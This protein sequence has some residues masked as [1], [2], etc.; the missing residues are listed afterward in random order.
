MRQF[1]VWLGCLFISCLSYALPFDCQKQ[2][3][4]AVVDAG[5][6]GS[7]LHVYTYDLDR[8][9]TPIHIQEQWV[10]KVSPGLASLTPSEIPNYL[11]QLIKSLPQTGLPV[12]F[13]STAGMRLLSNAQQEALYQGVKAWFSKQP[14]MHLQALKTISGAEEGV[15]GW[16]AANYQLGRFDSDEKPWIGVMDMGGASVQI[17]FPVSHTDDISA[18]D[19][20][21]ISLYGKP[22]TLFVHSFLGLGQTEVSHQLLDASSCYSTGYVLSDAEVGEGDV[23]QCEQKTDLLV[24]LHDVSRTVHDALLKN[25]VPH[26]FV[27]GGLSS[28]VQTSP[29][30]FEEEA[31]TPTTLRNEANAAFCETAWPDLY[32]SHPDDAYLNTK[33]LST[34]YYYSLLVN[35]YGFSPQQT[36]QFSRANSVGEWPLG[37]V[38]L[39]R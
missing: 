18:K 37:V 20:K 27:S 35:G 23:N 30:H 29:L 36:V 5:S 28:L 22:V 21:T 7:R 4:M 1:S 16:L 12:Y 33:C 39:Q 32:A 9:K 17:A 6:T 15:Y 24:N 14:Q 34:A 19:L 2:H 11:N 38:L 31:F 10:N 25:P 8:H 13:Y 3:C 26:W